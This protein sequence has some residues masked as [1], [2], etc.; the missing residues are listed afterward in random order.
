MFLDEHFIIKLSRCRQELENLC[1]TV[2]LAHWLQLHGQRSGPLKHTSGWTEHDPIA[3]LIKPFLAFFFFFASGFAVTQAETDGGNSSCFVSHCEPG[4]YTALLRTSTCPGWVRSQ[5]TQEFWGRWGKG[6]CLPACCNRSKAGMEGAAWSLLSLERP[7]SGKEEGWVSHAWSCTSGALY[8]FTC[9]KGGWT[10]R[11]FSKAFS[12]SQ[13]HVLAEHR[14]TR[15]CLEIKPLTRPRSVRVV[16]MTMSD[17]FWS[18]TTCQNCAQVCGRGPWAAMYLFT[19]WAA[20]ISI[21]QEMVQAL[22]PVTAA[23][24]TGNWSSHTSS[25]W[26]SAHQ[27]SST[28]FWPISIIKEQT[29]LEN[30]SKVFDNNASYSG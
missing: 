21:W 24:W 20:G 2:L 1:Y 9:R 8:R 7:T 23:R 22:E 3:V 16:N 11:H 12:S 17:N 30:A 5:L 14:V 18:Q 27:N 6:K 10:G 19:R 29:T 15:T 25:W 26:L 28:N 13:V 4:P